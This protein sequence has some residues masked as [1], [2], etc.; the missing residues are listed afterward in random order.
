M[1][2]TIQQLTPHLSYTIS[3]V[4]PELWAIIAHFASR[5]SLARFCCVSHDFQSTFSVFLYANIIDPP[6]SADQSSRLITT[7][8]DVQKPCWK[9]H[10]ALLIRK[11]GLTG[12][13][14]QNTTEAQNHDSLR[15]MYR[16][17]P[18]AECTSG[19]ALRVLHWN[20]E[21]GL[22]DLGQILGVPGHFPHL[23]EL[24]VS[25]NGNNNNFNVSLTS[26]CTLYPA[27]RSHSLSRL[28][29]SKCSESISVLV[30]SVCFIMRGLS[31]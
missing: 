3:G 10:P 15:N 14:S 6:L 25:S 17:I 22:D 5:Q 9:P 18:R 30:I 28:E 2:R 1:F 12:G 19:S 7:L 16:L 29:A 8:S 27:L 4:P 21:A 20:L 26:A 11:L 31:E 23:R 13:S 24:V